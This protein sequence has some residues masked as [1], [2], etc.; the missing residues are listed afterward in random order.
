MGWS[1][2]LRRF[3]IV[4]HPVDGLRDVGSEGLQAGGKQGD[5]EGGI[6]SLPAK[7]PYASLA[8]AWPESSKGGIT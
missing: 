6:D 5:G 7:L 2:A 4:F 1:Q 8:E 3:S